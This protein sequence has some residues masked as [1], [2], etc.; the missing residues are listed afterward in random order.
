MTYTNNT[1]T[2]DFGKIVPCSSPSTCPA[3]SQCPSVLNRHIPGSN[4]PTSA[5]SPAVRAV[6][7]GG[8]NERSELSP[9]S[10]KHVIVHIVTRLDQGNV[11]DAYINYDHA[12]THPINAYTH[13]IRAY[14]HSIHAYTHSIHAYTHSIH[15][16]NRVHG[17]SMAWTG[18]GDLCCTSAIA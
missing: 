7:L 2:K 18:A 4:H 14:T 10:N 13:S 5:L 12:Y 1:S 11:F 3:P 9:V 17:H 8:A 6:P 15:A 16:Y